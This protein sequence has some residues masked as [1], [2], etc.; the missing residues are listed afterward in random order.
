MK[1]ALST[2]IM[3]GMDVIEC[4][5]REALNKNTVKRPLEDITQIE[6]QNTVA[7]YIFGDD[8]ARL[9]DGGLEAG[10]YLDSDT[11]TQVIVLGA[12]NERITR[13]INRCGG[14]L[15]TL[16]LRFLN[17]E[18]LELPAR[19]DGL[20]RL[21]L[22]PMER[23]REVVGL[24]FFGSMT[25]LDLS[26]TNPGTVF[27]AT[28]FPLL[29]RLDLAGITDLARIEGLSG[30]S[31]LEELDL[32]GTSVGPELNLSALHNLKR[33][34]LVDMDRLQRVYG[35]G[36]SPNLEYIDL[37]CSGITRIPDDIQKITKPIHLDLSNLT[38]EDL[39][40]W[41]PELGL[42]FTLCEDGINLRGT[43]AFDIDRGLFSEKVTE[44]NFDEYQRRI[45][46]WF[47]ARKE[48]VPTPLN[49]IKVVFLG[50][51]D[52]GKSHTIARLLND[53]GEPDHRFFD[54]Q[55]TPGIAVYHKDYDLE[56]Q[57]IQVHYW[58]FGGQEIM[59]S[60][61]RIFLTRRTIYVVLL[62]TRDDNQSDR[63]K[64]WLHNIKSFAPDAPVLLVL[65]KI[66][67][68][69]NASVD[70]VA[71]R[72]I[73]E[74]LTQIV[75]LSA[76]DFSKEQFNERFTKVLLEE[77]QKTGFLDVR[78]PVA[79]KRV[80][81]RL[82]N[83]DSHYIS[84]NDY[85]NI[86][87]E[88]QVNE[89][90][91]ELLQWF[92]DLGVSFCYDGRDGYDLD[93]YVI[94]RPDWITNALYIILFNEL[95]G[96]DNGLVPHKSIHQILRSSHSN[97]NIRSTLTNARYNSGDVHYVLEIMRKFNLSFTHGR[98]QEF[99]PMLCQQ[100]SALDVQ[101]YRK[102]INT[103]EFNMEFDY[104]PNNLLYR[105]MVERHA[106]LDMDRVWCT[107]AQFTL[108]GA[109]LSAVVVIDGGT[110]RF[111]IRAETEE[112][113]PNTYL[114]MLKAN[115]DRIVEDMGMKPPICQLVYKLTDGQRE[116]FDFGLLKEMLDAGESHA[117][118]RIYRKQIPI[119]D[120]LNQSAPD[121][122]ENEEKLLNAIRKSCL[123]IQAEPD[124]Y[125]KDGESSWGMEDKRNRRVRDDLQ[126]LGYDVK[127]QTQR[128]HSGTGRGIG[129][130]DL[131][132]YN[133]KKEPWTIIEALRVSGGTKTDWNKHLD[134][135][136]ENYNYFGV[137][138]L[139][140]LTYVDSDV[141][142]FEQIWAAYLD[143]IPK[144]N[145]VMFTYCAGSLVVPAKHCDNTF[146]K[147]AKYRY[148]CGDNS[149]T[150]YH[151]F[152]HIPKRTG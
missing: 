20:E 18:I 56:G 145:P 85:Q 50:D 144:Y 15:R 129:E 149:M 147:T 73:H 70:E 89:H 117:Y 35:F 40:D 106:E 34:R 142:D 58:D 83:M 138:C 67:Q 65:N 48:N 92:N 54:G 76:R 101:D 71:L 17:V 128:G 47:A 19:F 51:G 139:Y 1:T 100:D 93:D 52:A 41:L 114:T 12:N 136:V 121:G 91:K 45:K 14:R 3:D 4:I 66:D 23:L 43:K 104:L 16:D 74:K 13:I 69:E 134:K 116:E 95:E 75:R 88:C 22:S 7:L 98:D 46:E 32:S 28:G 77:I 21:R 99:I 57:K 60:M 137:P 9:A 119:A 112:N 141:T 127:D 110:L 37:S 87:A 133:D 131:L 29:R 31:N 82:E 109:G 26:F 118:S 148:S 115:V 72:N 96:A 150:V 140:L 62:N 2:I 84:G 68:N 42:D 59:H 36:E 151:I 24:T 102:D 125:L 81:A 94:L 90:Q 10:C 27:D 105:L 79:W 107:G 8:T 146:I 33:I 126:M 5:R 80:K 120:I 6:W 55:S 123:N 30:L 78:W 132:L 38:L 11:A 143:H 39:P 25:E 135:L 113:S 122:L 63:A 44:E 152:V 49:E 53:G 111:F 103:L 97:S 64:Y 61:H 124:Y 86:C 130:L 108:S